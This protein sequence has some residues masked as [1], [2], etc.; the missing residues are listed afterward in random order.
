MSEFSSELSETSPAVPAEMSASRRIARLLRE[1]AQPAAIGEHLHQQI[2]RA[3]RRLGWARGRTR[4]LWY[5][6]ARR[7]DADE[8]AAAERWLRRHRA[9]GHWSMPQQAAYL[10]ALHER[11]RAD[12]ALETAARIE[13]A[14][15]LLAAHDRRDLA[16][17]LRQALGLRDRPV[18]PGRGGPE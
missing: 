4:R 17:T 18:A 12:A 8:I 16:D 10:E 14:L 5:G 9:M 2:E 6:E 15:R 7:V 1:V 13:A 3:A 11:D